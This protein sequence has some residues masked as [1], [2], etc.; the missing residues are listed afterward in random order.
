VQ[1]LDYD[2]IVVGVGAMGAATACQLARRGA[3]VALFEQFE[4][5]H[6]HGSSHGRSRIFRLAYENPAYI[7]LAQAALPLWQQIEE[8]TKTKLLT[9]TGGLDFGRRGQKVFNI[10][11]NLESAQIVCERLPAS[12][13]MERF[14]QF[15]L[16]EEIEGVFQP[17]A[18]VLDAELSVATMTGLA[19]ARGAQFFTETKIDRLK[20]FAGGVELVAGEKVYRAKKAVL[21]AGAYIQDLFDSFTATKLPLSISQEQYLFLQS[22]SPH[23]F[24]V[25]KFPVWIDYDAMAGARSYLSMYG[26]PRMAEPAANASHIKVACHM[27]GESVTTRM[28]DYELNQKVA[29]RSLQ[30]ISEILPQAYGP[31]ADFA[32]CLYTTTVNERFILDFADDAESIFLASPCSGHGFKF[33]PVIGEIVCQ[34]V[35]DG[36]TNHNIE[37]FNLK[38]ALSLKN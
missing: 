16:T 13:I 3:A 7:P 17:D 19:Q 4:L 24:D 26:F 5:N 15:C 23:L 34:L 2:V 12:A 11:E 37:L 27:S 8:L 35:L 25:G 31:I 22:P 32:S 6:K 20:T 9:T 33:A 21:A 14:P 1:N 38:Q 10:C 28:R 30:Y 29:N 18:G 36:K